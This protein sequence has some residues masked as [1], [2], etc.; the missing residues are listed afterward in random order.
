MFKRPG[1]SFPSLP[2]VRIEKWFEISDVLI[3][4]ENGELKSKGNLV[5][6][7]DQNKE[8]KDDKSSNL[9]TIGKSRTNNDAYAQFELDNL[10]VFEKLLDEK[11][12]GTWNVVLEKGRLNLIK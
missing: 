5:V 2:R 7:D 8:D 11:V 6:D 10:V 3:Y 12:V 9:I 1:V 4:Y